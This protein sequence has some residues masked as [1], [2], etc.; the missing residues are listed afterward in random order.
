VT[1]EDL[2]RKIRHYRC[3]FKKFKGLYEE[4][5]SNTCDPTLITLNQ[6][7]LRL[8]SPCDEDID[9]SLVYENEQEVPYTLDGTKIIVPGCDP[10]N[11]FFNDNPFAQVP[12]GDDFY[13]FVVDQDDNPITPLS[14]SGNTIQVNIPGCCEET[15]ISFNDDEPILLGCGETNFLL[16]DVDENPLTVIDVIDGVIRVN[17]SPCEDATAVLRDTENNI[18]STTPIASGATENITAPDGTVTITRD[19]LPFAVQAVRSG[20]TVSVEVPSDVNPAW[21]RPTG[22]LALDTVTTG[23][24]NFSGLFAVYEL[25]RNVNTIQMAG[26]AGNIIDWGDGTTQSNVSTTLYTK[27]YN[28]AT[29]ASPVLVDA[30]GLNYKMVVVNINLTGVTNLQIER[31]TTA[32]VVPNSRNLGWLD[33]ALDCATLTFLN[34]SNQGFSTR[35]QR[36]LIYNVGATLS[37]LAYF[38]QLAALRVLRFPFDKLQTTNQTFINNFGDVRDE[39]NQPISVNLAINNASLIS[40]MAGSHLTEIGN[41]TSPLSTTFQ[42]TLQNSIVLEKVGNISVPSAT[43]IVNGL[44]NCHK[45]KGVINITSSGL[46]TNINQVVFGCF[47]LDGLVISDCTNVTNAVNVLNNCRNLKTLILT[48]L[49]VGIT[50][51][52]CMLD[53]AAINAF[54]TSLGTASGSQTIFI[55]RNPGSATCDT[56][57]ATGKGFTVTI[58]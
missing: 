41:I 18:L 1:E 32:V 56:T 23:T 34:V 48:G 46:L 53:A 50:V 31:N 15:F 2:L 4:C 16:T 37:G 38:V 55:R 10:V 3:Q 19:S 54:F 36:L 52:D 57:I 42:S 35:L 20:A 17:V 9:F 43:N 29:I 26:G 30:A 51:D 21:Q 7:I 5:I 13:F 27:E 45:L 39:N 6:N 33:I 44:N 8:V 25:E 24:N 49:R 11:V 40:F 14:V 12:C 58:I 22:W 47:L 28:Y